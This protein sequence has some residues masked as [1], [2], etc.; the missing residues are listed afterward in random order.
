MGLFSFLRNRKPKE[1]QPSA[2]QVANVSVSYHEYTPAELRQQRYD[3]VGEIRR[4]Q[5]ESIPS[6]NG[7]RPHEILMLSYSPRYSANQDCFPRFWS[8][9]YAVPNPSDVLRKL[10]RDGFIRAGT[11]M[12]SLSWL[13]LPS[14]K[15]ILLQQGLKTSGK[16]TD[17]I[18]RIKSDVLES[19]IESHIPE[20]HYVLTA[21]GESELKE[22]EYV[23]SL[24]NKDYGV[25]VWDVNKALRGGSSKHWRDAVWGELNRELLDAMKYLSH[26]NV[27]PMTSV[28]YRQVDFLKDEGR[29]DQAIVIVIDAL[30]KEIGARAP[31]GFL[32]DKELYEKGI[33]TSKQPSFYRS[34]KDYSDFGFSLLDDLLGLNAQ[35][36]IIPDAS[37]LCMR[38]SSVGNVVTKSEFVDLVSAKLSH[39]QKLF[40]DICDNIQRRIC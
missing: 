36:G 10:E 39:N 17:L 31:A 9:K 8:Y 35:K 33:D 19:V 30:S 20:R 37:E 34:V 29:I 7:L 25:S 18:D 3:E 12:E 5:E 32:L 16:K 13:T 4:L 1:S 22:N 2:M 24:H 23:V 14:L 6:R 15:A 11:A 40:H 21:I 28:M 27:A 38:L 26:G